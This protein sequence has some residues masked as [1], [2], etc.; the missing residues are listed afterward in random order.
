[1][2]KLVRYGSQGLLCLFLLLAFYFLAV[3][4]GGLVPVNR[5][6]LPTVQG[7]PVYLQSNGAH[8]DIVF[9]VSTACDCSHQRAPQYAVL[10]RGFDGAIPASQWQWL[11]AGW[12]NEDFMLHVPTWNDLTPGIALRAIS[13]AGGSVIRLSSHYEPRSGTNTARLLLTPGQYRQL[14]AYVRAGMGQ[15][16]EEVVASIAGPGD[17][18][19]RSGDRYSLFNTCNE[20]VRRGVARAGI[21]TVWWTPFDSALLHH[22]GR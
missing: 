17:R 7:I 9:P 12:G 4:L 22:F 13:G 14:L 21:R 19:Y 6:Y 16:P 11:A 18:F 20:W 1:M 15:V 8:I 10:E 3:V 2:G 5:D